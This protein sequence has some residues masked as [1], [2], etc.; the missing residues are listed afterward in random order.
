[1]AESPTALNYQPADTTLVANGTTVTIGPLSVVLDGFDLAA[2]AECQV[3][4]GVNVN[5]PSTNFGFV[6]TTYTLTAAQLAAA[7]GMPA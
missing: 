7:T 5:S 1:M 4:T 6:D 2:G 3:G